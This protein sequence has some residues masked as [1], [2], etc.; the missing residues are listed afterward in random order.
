M[1]FAK[2]KKAE[3]EGELEKLVNTSDAKGARGLYYSYY[4]KKQNKQL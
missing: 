1:R 4:W 2:E 3:L